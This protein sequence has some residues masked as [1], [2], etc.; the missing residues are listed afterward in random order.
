[1]GDKDEKDT[2]SL[3]QIASDVEAHVEGAGK[4]GAPSK[5]KD[6]APEGTSEK[7]SE[8]QKEKDAARRLAKVRQ[9]LASQRP[10]KKRSERIIRLVILLVFVSGVLGVGWVCFYPS[11]SV[12]PP[13][14]DV[15]AAKVDTNVPLDSSTGDIYN[16]DRE[17]FL[18]GQKKVASGDYSGL[19][20]IKRLS[21]ISPESPVTAN[22]LLLTAATYRYNLGKPD[23][24]INAY[25]LFLKN[26]PKH[27]RANITRKNLI[28]MLMEKGR[29]EE[30]EKHIHDLLKYAETEHDTKFADYYLKKLP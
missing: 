27:K 26:F 2:R 1:M 5:K 11:S 23:D 16:K 21:E 6:P 9:T 28:E 10:R 14:I 22:A 17:I 24:A 25:A 3:D 12:K 18:K 30:A 19:E 15:E 7:K 8:D 29:H 20:D 13:D 4:G